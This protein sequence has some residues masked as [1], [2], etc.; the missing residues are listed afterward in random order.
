MPDWTAEHM[1]VLRE[2]GRL[3]IQIEALQRRHAQEQALSSQSVVRL[4]AQ[5]IIRDTLAYWGMGPLLHRQRV[6][7][8]SHSGRSIGAQEVICHSG[9][10]AHAHAWLSEGDQCRLLGGTCENLSGR[11]AVSKA[12]SKTAPQ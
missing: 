8:A 12:S 5:L 7:S 11:T 6:K 2:W 9:C 1:A 4:R 10:V 3:Q